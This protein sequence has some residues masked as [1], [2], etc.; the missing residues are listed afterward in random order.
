MYRSG[1]TADEV[2]REAGGSQMSDEGELRALAEKAIGGNPKQTEQY[3]S[4]KTSLFG[5]FVGQVMKLSGGRA[6]PQVVNDVLKQLLDGS[7]DE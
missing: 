6:N 5:F 1:R 2:V 7:S 4:G 3:R